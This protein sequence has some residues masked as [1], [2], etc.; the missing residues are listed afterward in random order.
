MHGKE[1]LLYEKGKL[2]G[3]C[4]QIKGN[5]FYLDLGDCSC[6]IVGVDEIQLRS[7]QDYLHANNL[8]KESQGRKIVELGKNP[9]WT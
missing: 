7:P 5:L 1:R 8:S 9:K 4:K 6:L 3:S 2:I